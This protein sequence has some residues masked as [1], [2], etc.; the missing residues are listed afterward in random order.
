MSKMKKGAWFNP[1]EREIPP[2]LASE[3]LG[4]LDHNGDEST[5]ET[6]QDRNHQPPLYTVEYFCPDFL[7]EEIRKCKIK[8]VDCGSKSCQICKENK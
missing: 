2:I 1:V 7:A 5:I 6:Y 4:W 3:W 8:K